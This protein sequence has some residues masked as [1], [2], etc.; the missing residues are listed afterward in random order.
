VAQQD[1]R[2]Q[3]GSR[4]TSLGFERKAKDLVDG[5]PEDRQEALTRTKRRRSRKSSED[6]GAKVESV[7]ALAAIRRG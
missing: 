6:A 1:Q 4:V 5:A 2:H 7:I 3:G